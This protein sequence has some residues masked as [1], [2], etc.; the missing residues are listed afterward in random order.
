[1]TTCTKVSTTNVDRQMSIRLRVDLL[2]ESQQA[3]S[4]HDFSYAFRFLLTIL[5][6][7]RS[8]KDE[9]LRSNVVKNL[10]SLHKELNESQIS[11]EQLLDE[12]KQIAIN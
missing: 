12:K 6:L 10:E 9:H 4:L 3:L 5:A 1:M 2:L 7:V 11:Y 8:K